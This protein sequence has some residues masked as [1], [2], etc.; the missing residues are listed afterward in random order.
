MT[1]FFFDA[2]GFFCGFQSPRTFPW[3]CGIDFPLTTRQHPRPKCSPRA[4]DVTE[5]SYR[6]YHLAGVQPL[7]G[8]GSTQ[9]RNHVIHPGKIQR[10]LLITLHAHSYNVHT[11][12]H[13]HSRAHIYFILMLTHTHTLTA[14]R[15]FFMQ[16]FALLVAKST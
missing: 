14:T 15:T 11:H 9:T 1:R 13:T 8:D 5:I 4:G 12:T 6:G 16:K 10:Y 2:F 3:S 7:S